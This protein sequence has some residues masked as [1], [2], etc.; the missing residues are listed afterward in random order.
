MINRIMESEQKGKKGRGKR[1]KKVG[2]RKGGKV[3]FR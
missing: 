2:G 1:G 3:Y